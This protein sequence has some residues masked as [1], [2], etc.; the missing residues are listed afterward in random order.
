MHRAMKTIS[1]CGIVQSSAE[2]ERFFHALREGVDEIVLGDLSHSEEVKK[3]AESFKAKVITLDVAGD[4]S[5]YRN[6][7]ISTATSDWIL[8]LDA[9]EIIHNYDLL[10]LRKLLERDDA[11]AYLITTRNYTNRHD[12]YGWIACKDIR[13]FNG[14][15]STTN[16]R[17]FKNMDDLRFKYK[18]NETLMPAVLTLKLKLKKINDLFVHNYGWEEKHH[19]YLPLLEQ[20][21]REMPKDL[22]ARYDLA[23]AYLERKQLG[24]A[25]KLFLSILKANPQYRRTLLHI[26]SIALMEGKPEIAARYLKRAIELNP[27]N[28]SA[29]HNLGILFKNNNNLEKAEWLFKK[30]LS[31]NQRQPAT[32]SLLARTYFEQGKSEEAKDL[33][34]KAIKLFPNH[35]LLQERKSS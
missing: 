23:K 20:Q 11:D 27:R 18:V 9:D 10:C 33:L 15:F 31:L 30:A 5:T 7:L 8:I 16:V 3:I 28:F 6:A 35:P 29:Y 2:L 24:A 26:S 32:I 21:F 25:K 4:F 17:L 34:E 22:K 1:V 19:S 13:G 12:L 14:F